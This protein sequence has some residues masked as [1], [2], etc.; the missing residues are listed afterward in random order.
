MAH[1]SGFYVASQLVESVLCLSEPL[2]S[3]YTCVADYWIHVCWGDGSLAVPLIKHSFARE[4][5]RSLTLY[6]STMNIS[7]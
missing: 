1:N 4:C 7:S 6:H 2:G 3:C 5:L